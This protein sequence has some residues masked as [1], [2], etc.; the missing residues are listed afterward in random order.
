MRITQRPY[1]RQLG[2]SLIEV[3]IAI[4]IIAVGVLGI[5]KMQALSISSSQV[6]GGRGLVALQASSLAALFHSNRGYWQTFSP[7]LPPC[8]NTAGCTLTGSSTTQFGA[9]PA[10]CTV[11]TPCLSSSIAALEI[12]NWMANINKQVPSYSANISCANGTT[13]PTNCT[14]AISWLEKQ[15]G[16]N[17]TTAALAST[18]ATKQTYF[19][20]VQ[21]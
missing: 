2:V 6:S 1:A 8:S 3:L 5:A 21:P 16:G 10:S 14:I 7:G 12:N 11:A 15:Q 13:L 20:Y 17:S 9:V 18:T 19:L 4:L